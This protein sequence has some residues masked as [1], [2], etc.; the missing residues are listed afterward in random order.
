M[1]T[2]QVDRDAAGGSATAAVLG[3]QLEVVVIPVSDVDRAQGVL[4]RV[5]AG[6]STRM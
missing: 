6:G 3:M 5:W 1:S 2:E 4:R